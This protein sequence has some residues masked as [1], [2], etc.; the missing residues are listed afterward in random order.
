MG[1]DITAYGRLEKLDIAYDHN[2]EEPALREG[3]QFYFYPHD[4]F[5]K[6]MEGVTGVYE[7]SGWGNS[8]HF[9]AGSY[10]GY[11]RWREHLAVMV[12]IDQD[13]LWEDRIEQI[14]PFVEI[15]NFTDCDGTIG[16]ATS[17]K[18][19]KDFAEWL[20]RAEAHAKSFTDDSDSQDWWISRYRNFMSAFA[21]ASDGGAV[22]F[23]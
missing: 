12:G 11:N 5:P 20:D 2:T 18:L 17:A 16:P 15:I 13:A 3:K 6:Q 19:F 22:K 21:L 23:H 8:F 10:S 7:L 9:R 1:L 14:G 4:E